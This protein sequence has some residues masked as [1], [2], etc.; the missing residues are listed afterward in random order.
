LA[1]GDWIADWRLN[2]RLA[3]ADLIADSTIAG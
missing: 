3:I 2:R 1:I